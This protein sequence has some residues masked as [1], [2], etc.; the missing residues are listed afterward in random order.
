MIHVCACIIAATLSAQVKLNILRLHFMLLL[1]TDIGGV[2]L[3]LLGLKQW[4][5]SVLNS[6]IFQSGL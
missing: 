4:D 6:N 3:L 1:V 2:A 5:I